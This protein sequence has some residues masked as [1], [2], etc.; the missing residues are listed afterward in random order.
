MS[1]TNAALPAALHAD[2][3]N[4][5]Y[6]DQL[7]LFGRFVGSWRIDNRLRNHDGAWSN[8]PGRW[9]FG[10]TLDGLAIQDVLNCPTAPNRYPGTTI[11]CYHPATNAWHAVWLD[12]HS[13]LY[14]TLKAS[15]DG[16]QITLDG[17]THTG[18]R[19]HWKFFDVATASFRW[20]GY[21]ADGDGSFELAQEMTAH[22]I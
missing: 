6:T 17:T 5:A 7:A 21:L 12:P 15:T 10:W 4:P 20:Q 18:T 16:A 2:G 3:P 9:D 1:A 13:G 8:H 11:R 19:V 14:V 22:R